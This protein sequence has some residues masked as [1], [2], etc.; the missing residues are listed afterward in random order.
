MAAQRRADKNEIKATQHASGEART[1][2]ATHAAPDPGGAPRRRHRH[3]RPARPPPRRAGRELLAVPPLRLRRAGAP[4]RLAPLRARRASLCARAGMGGR[5]HG[6]DLARPLA[7]DGVRLGA[8]A[9]TPSSTA[10][11]SSRSRSPRCWSQAGERVGMPG[12]DAADRQPQRARPD[13]ERDR[14]RRDRAREPAAVVRAVAAL[15]DRG[16]VR[17]LEPDR[18]RSAR[19]SRSCPSTG[20]HGHVVQIV[21][22]AEETFPYSGRVEF[23]EP[24]G[25]GTITAGRAETWR[26][27]YETRVARHRAEIRAE[28]DRLG[29]SF[30]IHRTDRPATELLLALHARMARRP[31]GAVVDRRHASPD[32]GRSRMIR[33]LPLGFAQPLVLLGLLSLPVLWWLLRLIPPRPRRIDFPPTRLLFDIT[34]KE[35]TPRAHAVVA[36]AA[37]ADARRAGH[38]RRRRPAVESA[39]RDLDAPTAPLALL[40]D[41]G[42]PA[43][44]TWDARMRTAEDLIARAETDNRGVALVPLSETGRDIS[45]ETAGARRACGSSS[46]SRSRTRSTAPT[47]CRRIGRFLG[48]DAGRRAGLALRR[49]RSRPR[50]R[51]RRRA[52]AGS[53]SNAPDHRGRRRRSAG[54]RAR[55]RRQRGRR[56]HR[57]GSA[58]RHR[59]RARAGI[60]RA[61]DLKGLPLGDASLRLQ[62]RTSARPR[63]SSTCRSRSATTS[64]ASRSPASARPAPCSCSTSAGAAARSASSP[65]RPPT[66][67][68]RCSPRPT[69]WR[70]RSARSP[71]CGWPTAAR[72][73]QAVSQFIEQRLPMLILADVGNVAEAR[74]R[75]HALDRGRR[76]AGALRRPAARRRRRRSRAGEAAARR[77]HAR[78]QP[79]LGPAA[80]A[81]RLLAREPVRR[82]GGADRRDREPPGAG[83]ARRRP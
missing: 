43:A 12:P 82:H 18:A 14:A 62:G 2:A 10:R 4:R 58:R 15:R 7:L 5:A 53:S 20:A 22:P 45:L 37:A 69:I 30:A 79:E 63:P 40:I 8:R 81:R 80:A 23:I 51:I 66:P 16:A 32:A 44:G 19:R 50:Q 47:R 71:T 56:A 21:D 67:R 55:R 48:R 33:G 65:A 1:L 61:L 31:R 39:G 28:T 59:Q 49:R 52:R 36:D 70:A 35:E 24:E 57:Q 64:R 83:R 74:E 34:P 76:R 29:W 60:V 78:R 17:L 73:P 41:D 46:S 38:P 77:P 27:D 26:A 11:W 25:A 3:P 75:A 6:L 42:F 54:A 13:G 68:S 9:A 72:P